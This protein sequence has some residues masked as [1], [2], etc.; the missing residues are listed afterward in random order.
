MYGFPAD[1][2]LSTAIGQE[3][4]QLRIGPHD[5]QFSFGEVTFAVQSTVELRRGS[6]F[7]SAWHAGEWPGSDFYQV[8][9]SPVT[10][11]HR[12][13]ER[14]LC[15]ALANGLDLHLLDTSDQYESLQIRISGFLCVV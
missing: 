8:F 4:T 5:L 15:I 12:I 11:M 3:T 2:D 10:K 14:R 6:L 13:D 9:G 1:L 7:V